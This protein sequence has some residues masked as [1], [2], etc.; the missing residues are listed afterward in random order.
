MLT[1]DLRPSLWLLTPKTKVY[2]TNP[3]VTCTDI[4]KVAN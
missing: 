1:I 2:V 4:A 3:K